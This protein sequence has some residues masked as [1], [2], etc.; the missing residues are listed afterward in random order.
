MKGDTFPLGSIKEALVTEEEEG[1]GEA[2]GVWSDRNVDWNKTD[3]VL[4]AARKSSRVLRKQGKT[5]VRGKE[6]GERRQGG[7]EKPEK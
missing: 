3:F 5:Q 4:W 1:G 7:G 6:S 2:W